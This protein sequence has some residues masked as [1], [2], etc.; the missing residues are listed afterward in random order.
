M[1]FDVL[2]QFIDTVRTEKIDRDATE[3]AKVDNFIDEDIIDEILDI[4]LLAY[5]EGVK[6]A[7]E[8]LMMTIEPSVEEAQEIINRPTDGKTFEERVRE[9]LEGEMGNATGSPADAIARVIETDG[10]RIYNEAK[11]SAGIKGGAKWKVWNT[12]EDMRVRDTHSFLEGVS[13]PIDGKFYT[14]DGDSAQAPGQ[15][16]KASNNCNCRCVITLRK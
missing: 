11:L 16:E 1:F 7:G 5:Y 13:A 10:V 12:M 8:E 15:F 14:Y 6:E 9:Y 3:G 4:F 2:D